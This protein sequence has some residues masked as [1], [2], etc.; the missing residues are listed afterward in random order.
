MARRDFAAGLLVA[1]LALPAVAQDLPQLKRGDVIFQN[2][3]S[4]QSLAI[5]LAT[6]SP[7]THVGIVDFDADGNPVVLEA[8]RTTRET[9][10]ADWVAQGEA[11]DVAIY[12]MAGLGED[13]AQAVTRAAR[14]HFGK[15]YDPYFYQTEDALYCSELVHIAFRDG[16]GVA[17]GRVETLADLNLDSAAAQELIADRWQSHP[18]CTD[19]QASDADACLALIRDAPLV[20]PQAVAEDTRLQL[21]WSSFED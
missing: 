16:V 9:P 17:L 21:V 18:A 20:T 5:L 19:G 14:S 3:R 12:R 1:L 13:Q 8:V 11:N 2:S 4:A 7:F 10:L 6:D 15:G